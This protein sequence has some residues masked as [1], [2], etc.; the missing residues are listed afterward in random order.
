M[1]DN[2]TIADRAGPS[3]V[4]PGPETIDAT[5]GPLVGT[6]IPHESARSHVTGEAVYIDDIPPSR[7]ELLVDFV[8]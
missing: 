8:G 5:P 3:E 1:A 2:A 6:S 4:G 7:G